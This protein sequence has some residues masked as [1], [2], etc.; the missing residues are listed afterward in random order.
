MD[1]EREEYA[2]EQIV[3]KQIE[4]G[5]AKYLVK[6]EGFSSSEN[7]WEPLESLKDSMDLVTEFE[8]KCRNSRRSK[9]VVNYA[10]KESD[11]PADAK[12]NDTVSENDGDD[13]Y[14]T[15][16]EEESEN[17]D[18]YIEAE[19]EDDDMSLKEADSDE[20]SIAMNNS[21]SDK[22]TDA[23][24]SNL[25]DAEF[26][27]TT[28]SEETT[29][30]IV[31]GSSA[32]KAVKSG[33]FVL[34]KNFFGILSLQGKLINAKDSTDAKVKSNKW[35]KL[36]VNSLGLDFN[37]KYITKSLGSIPSSEVIESFVNLKNHLINFEYGGAEDDKTLDMA[38]NPEMTVDRKKWIEKHQNN[39]SFDNDGNSETISF[40]KFIDHYYLQY[41]NI[42]TQQNSPSAVDGQ[43][44]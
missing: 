14:L 29:L 19:E 17:D 32:M 43:T 38:F 39:L 33:L 36:I 15:E 1:D 35:I 24:S 21:T 20:E 26:A 18:V 5:N 11:S 9:R 3:D 13:D 8:N 31:E 23:L 12:N 2:V 7:T 40:K 37:K 25:V 34:E 4:N 42:L 30:I 44:Q 41:C 6:W 22:Q 10:E 27:G 16:D 28:Q